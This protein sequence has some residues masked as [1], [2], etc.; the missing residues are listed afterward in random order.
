MPDSPGFA[1]VVL[2]A[3]M[4]KRM[5]SEIPK[6][7]HRVAGKPMVAH[8]LDAVYE[9]GASRAVVVVGHKG[10]LVQ[11]AVGDRARCVVQAE[12]LGTGHAVMQAEE[13]LSDYTGTVLVVAGDTPLVTGSTLRKLVEAHRDSGAAATVLTAVLDDPAGYGRVVRSTEGSVVKIVEHKD[14]SPAELAIREINTGIFVFDKEK[15]FSA[16]ALVDNDN[17]QGEYY[18]PDVITIMLGR[19]EKVGAEVTETPEETLGVNSR[20]Q[21]AAVEAV[22]RR[23]INGRL[24]DQGVTLIDPESTFID[25]DVEIGRDTVI[26]PFT[27]IEGS[28]RIGKNC[29]I[30]PSVHIVDS[31]IGDG[32]V[33]EHTVLRKA[34]VEPERVE[35]AGRNGRACK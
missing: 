12:Q 2:A 6:V 17:A 19:G 27:V 5:K 18:L 10:E 8:V 15:L 20:A 33:C 21:L 35:I 30:G 9:A 16:L 7:L 22:L 1:A 11:R 14:A 26:Y 28:T 32:A 29:T 25:Q 34:K 24:M 3:G 23:R 13:A 4:G 31:E